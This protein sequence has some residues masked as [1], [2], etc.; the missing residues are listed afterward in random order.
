MKEAISEANLLR[1]KSRICTENGDQKQMFIFAKQSTYLLQRAWARREN[2]K[3]S[4]KPPYPTDSPSDLDSLVQSVRDLAFE[5]NSVDREN[6]RF[7]VTVGPYVWPLVRPILQ[8]LLWMVQTAMHCG[9]IQEVKHAYKQA[10]RLADG[11]GSD[12]ILSSVLVENV[13]IACLSGETDEGRQLIDRI[14]VKRAESD[15]SKDLARQHR[16]IGTLL[17]LEGHC[18]AEIGYYETAQHILREVSTFNHLIPFE[19]INT[20]IAPA[21]ESQ[22]TPL[23]AASMAHNSR[24]ITQNRSKTRKKAVEKAINCA[25][26]ME[27]APAPSQ[28]NDCF[29]LEL[30]QSDLA[31]LTVECLIERGRNLDA[32]K[33]LSHIPESKSTTEH[34]LRIAATRAKQSLAEG[35]MMMSKD[36]VL[37]MLTESALSLP[38]TSLSEQQM[39][40][41]GY[42]GEEKVITKSIQNSASFVDYLFQSIQSVS[43]TY[44]GSASSCSTFTLSECQSVLI[45]SSLMLSI[46]RPNAEKHGIHAAKVACAIGEH[47]DT[48][49]KLIR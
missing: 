30:L 32:T 46:S 36:S 34:H 42:G 40:S 35:E 26:P 44:Y 24:H 49:F 14:A 31:R 19:G 17:H 12:T 38:A 10:E 20:F 13:D 9:D 39:D 23:T 22:P 16:C 4:P 5:T 25:L 37:S 48:S 28:S 45:T 7:N 18:S 1:L 47:R 29:E 41:C 8:S 27:A 15:Q 11:L 2:H 33:L 6:D 3:S 21:P 43:E